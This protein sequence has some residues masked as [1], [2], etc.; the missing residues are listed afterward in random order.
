[1]PA[2]AASLIER[3]SSGLRAAWFPIILLVALGLVFGRQL[4]APQPVLTPP[5]AFSNG[6]STIQAT[7]AWHSAGASTPNATS[8]FCWFPA[9][10]CQVTVAEIVADGASSRLQLADTEF[11][12]TQLSDATLTAT[13]KNTDPCHVESLRLDR[14]ARTATLI[15]GPSGAAT[16]AQ[17]PT[18]TATLGS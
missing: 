16:C 12:I 1:M 2:G 6:T 18:L 13:S 3:W 11:D 10:S 5:F 7:G 15:V 4:S 14:K 9:T 17:A 8:I